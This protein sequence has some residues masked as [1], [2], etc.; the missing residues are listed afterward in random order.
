MEQIFYIK[1]YLNL[2]KNGSHQV[3]KNY[4]KLQISKIC[5]IFKG[6]F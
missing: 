5:L 6:I 4:N 1:V 2:A 3:R